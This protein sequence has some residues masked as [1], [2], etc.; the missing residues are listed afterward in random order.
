M[1]YPMSKSQDLPSRF[2]IILPIVNYNDT[3]KSSKKLVYS[4]LKPYLYFKLNYL[5]QYNK[6][7][8]VCLIHYFE[9]PIFLL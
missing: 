5:Y 9:I 4:L 1:N 3:S 6:T 7:L 8:L 2:L